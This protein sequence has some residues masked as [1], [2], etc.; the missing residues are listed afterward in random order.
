MEP[1]EEGFYRR[2]EALN[3]AVQYA[4]G[5]VHYSVEDVITDAEL[6]LNWLNNVEVQ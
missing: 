6:F 5:R 3:L 1:I 4:R 2:Q